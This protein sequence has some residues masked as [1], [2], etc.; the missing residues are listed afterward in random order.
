M[1]SLLV[2]AFILSGLLSFP[3]MAM[4]SHHGHHHSGHI[5][6]LKTEKKRMPLGDKER[7]EVIMVFKEN[8]RLHLAFY[9]YKAKEVEKKAKQVARAILKISHPKISKL[10]A[11]SQKKL[12]EIRANLPRDRNDQNYHLFSTALIHVINTYDLGKIYNAHSCSMKKMKWIQNT[13]KLPQIHNPYAPEMKRCG[14]Q[15]TNY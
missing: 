8:E 1:R 11:F 14:S 7:K 3:L 13:Q 9:Q 12:L 6:K 15:D 4:D 10:L 2:F 5:M